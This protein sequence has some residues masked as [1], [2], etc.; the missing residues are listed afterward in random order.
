MIWQLTL[1]ASVMSFFGVAPQQYVRQSVAMNLSIRVIRYFTALRS[2]PF[3]MTVCARYVI[4]NEVKNLSI[5][6]LDI[7]LP[8]VAPRHL[9]SKSGGV[10][11][12]LL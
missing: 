9:P 2:V 12:N 11:C 7:S 5:R 8:S 6:G 3:S 10:F 1:D 4:L